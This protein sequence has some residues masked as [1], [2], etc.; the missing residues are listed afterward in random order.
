[1]KNKATSLIIAAIAIYAAFIIYKLMKPF[2]YF[3]Y[4]E[5]DS[6]DL[7]GS[8][9]EFMN[10]EFI[11]KLD[12]I[13]EDVGFPLKITSGFRTKFHNQKVGG[14]K[15]SAHTKGLAADIATPSGKGQKEIV[16][17]ALKQ[18]INR[19]GFGTNFI[20]LDVDTSKRPNVTWGYGN[21]VPSFSEIKNWV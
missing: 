12:K 2:T 16:A 9:K 18:G 13:R 3:S 17:A 5:F 1:M 15:K 20:H 7:P 6:P 14:V 10:K 19:F 4:S 8:G 11:Q 21:S